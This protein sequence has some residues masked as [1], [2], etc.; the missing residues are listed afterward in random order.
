[1]TSPARPHVLKALLR[2]AIAYAAAGVGAP[3]FADRG[4]TLSTQQSGDYARIVAKWADGDETAPK[5]SAA[6]NSQ[7]LVV[8]FDQAVSI[9]L[10]AL[11]KGLPE[12]AA[13]ARMDA[14]NRT[15]RIAL[16]QPSKL[17][18]ATSIDLAGID[19][20]REDAKA[21]PPPLVSPLVAKRAA[22][23]EAK[24]IAALPPPPEEVKLEVKGSDLDGASRIAFYWQKPASF[25]SE[26]IPGGL[27]LTFSKRAKAD[28]AYVHISPPKRL[29]EIKGENTP[30]GY[31]ATIRAKD[32]LAMKAFKD[33]DLVIV[34]IND[35][36]RDEVAETVRKVQEQ[37][38][39]QTADAAAKA[40]AKSEKAAAKGE[41]PV[42]TPASAANPA[43][44]INLKP[45]KGAAAPETATDY[46]RGVPKLAPSVVLG[47][48]D[49]KTALAKTWAEPAPKSGVIEVRST[50]LPGGVELT[51]PFTAP[52]PAAVFMRG[53]AAWAVF[54]AN[55]D[56]RLDR[57][58]APAG[59]KIR[60]FR[61]PNAALLRIETPS[62]ATLSAESREADWVIRVAPGAQKPSRFLKP[63]RSAGADGKMRVETMMA[64]AAGIVW[65]DDPIVRD[66]IA[67]VTAY[68]PSSASPTGRDF[69]EAT[70]PA[71]AHG[72][73]I[74]PKSDAVEVSLEGE[75]VIVSMTPGLAAAD[76][77][78][79]AGDTLTGAS[80]A[81]PAFIDFE[82]LGGR[83]GAD[84]YR[85]REKLEAATVAFAP[86]SR[87]GS[88]AM[89]ELARFYI[90]NELAPE[91]LGVLK[92]AASIRPELTQDA[93]FLGLRA[94][95]QVMAHRLK[96]AKDDLAK[97]PLWQDP[98]AALW[99]GLIAVE[100]G[101]YER[102]MDFFHAGKSLI[103]AYPPKWSAKFEAAAAEAAFHT[104]DF[105]A[106]RRWASKAA[107]AGDAETQARAQLALAN[108]ASALEG[109][110]AAFPQYE[111]LSKGPFE[112][113]AVAAEL[114]RLEAGVQLGKVKPSDGLD[115]LESLRYRWRGDGIELATVG[116]LADQY[117]RAGRFREALTLPQGVAS[118]K[119]EAAGARDLRLKL[120][121]Y[122]RR[123]F[124]DGEA[125]KLDPIQS[126]ALFYEFKDLT[127]VGADGDQ[128]IR[129]LARRLV[130]F[131]LLEPAAQLLQHQV[132]N[133]VRGAGKAAIAADLATIYLM[134]KR[135]EM[136]IGAINGSRQPQLRPELVL[137]RRL[138][139]AAAYRDLG[140]YDHVI[141]L[142]E[143]LDGVEARQLLVDAY[144]RDRKWKEAADALVS[145]LPPPDKADPAKD[146]DNALRAA[147]AARLAKEPAILAKLRSG[148]ARLFQ[149]TNKES[150]D[151]ITAQTDVSGGSISEAARRLADA[152]RVDA[153]SAAMKRRFEGKDAPAASPAKP[154]G[155]AAA[156]KPA[157]TP[158]PKPAAPSAAPAAGNK[159]A[160]RPSGA[161]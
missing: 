157:A 50:P 8:H 151:L 13:I 86:D 47:G 98:S 49:R 83:V 113:V 102:A 100:E 63:Q 9:D 153:F 106:G 7:V 5:I 45:P 94:A 53:Q 58:S 92:L 57:A 43:G 118:R 29:A 30:A 91:G 41:A 66:R 28:L 156:A 112:P 108:I 147:I 67:A 146:A 110:E 85:T 38:A 128:M 23:A 125:D 88:A 36:G 130:A 93:G 140:R 46:P 55:A 25:K 111:K 141:E 4:V 144:W 70:M 44:P 138:I 117:M 107:Q 95:G 31:V 96:G 35:P 82:K 74:A 72:L 136:A 129:K 122:F 145:L 2:G 60:A 12:W 121:D 133:R 1:M 131:D 150:F 48:A 65:F 109:P 149:T 20:V 68:G 97:G 6:I 139:E 87:E 161:G 104:N 79:A 123:L 52:A 116:I 56:L 124:L 40:A 26:P 62:N 80:E 14:D 73:A 42:A 76:G 154:G 10:E 39:R 24:R 18:V 33:D 59:F 54:A 155:P 134:D 120:V 51:V 132:D 75:K 11:K 101:E 160:S 114:K 84:F 105:D 137:E 19:I 119:G 142:V 99:S 89:I 16:K 126:L 90:A 148:Y 143:P 22:E 32:G 64:G 71:T 135:P 152:S 27:K 81:G 17:K 115:Q 21:A 37:N 61:Q 127:P 69:V 158:A 34:D 15:A 159:S 78:A 3:A 77:V 103:Y